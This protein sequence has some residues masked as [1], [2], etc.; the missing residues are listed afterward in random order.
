MSAFAAVKNKL[1]NSPTHVGQS[2]SSLN[3]QMPLALGYVQ[4]NIVKCIVTF[5]TVV[6][7]FNSPFSMVG[8]WPCL[9]SCGL[10]PQRTIMSILRNSFNGSRNMCISLAAHTQ[11]LPHFSSWIQ[12]NLTEFSP[13]PFNWLLLTFPLHPSFVSRTQPASCPMP[14][15]NHRY[16]ENEAP[17]GEHKKPPSMDTRWRFKQA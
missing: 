15:D 10:N 2:R 3:K 17:D 13:F 6:T 7:S 8:F 12:D 1:D 16:V 9:L 11:F 14:D 5:E 4:K